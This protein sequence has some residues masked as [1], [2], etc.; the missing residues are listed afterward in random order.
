MQ[1]LEE[2]FDFSTRP[3]TKINKSG[4]V[5]FN[6]SLLAEFFNNLLL[7]QQGF[8]SKYLQTFKWPEYGC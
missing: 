2:Y 1:F 6:F 3:G 5:T 4:C 7:Q 8:S